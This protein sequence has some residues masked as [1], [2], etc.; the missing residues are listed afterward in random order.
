MF[1]KTP[2]PTIVG[3]PRVGGTVV[4]LVGAWSPKPSSY[5]YQWYR[6]GKAISGATGK[7]YKVRSADRSTKLTVKVTGKRSGYISVTTTSSPKNIGKTFSTT[8][9]PRIWGTMKAGHTVKASA[10]YWSP[11]VTS[12]QYQWLRNGVAIGGA[13]KS[14]YK[15]TSAD[16]GKKISVRV[17]GKRWDYMPVTKTSPARWVAR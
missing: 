9:T 3:I 1:S 7:I 16:K 13:T 14:T 5:S 11:L 17:T 2:K 10:G 6:N 15:I 12:L 8:V 4:A